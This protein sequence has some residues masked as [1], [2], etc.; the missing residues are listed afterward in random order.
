MEIQKIQTGSLDL[1]QGL[2]LTDL[3]L[4]IL[5]DIVSGKRVQSI[6]QELG[7]P[8][9][10]IITLLSK[11]KV[12]EFMQ[13]MIDARNLAIKMELPNLLTKIIQDKIDA[14]E[15]DGETLGSTSRKDIVDIIKVLSDTLK[16]TDTVQTK[17]EGDSF[18]N[19]YQKIN[20]IQGG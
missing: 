8:K 15:A 13:Q 9:A 6:S 1:P 14:A 17:E 18:T 3:E 10:S 7:V 4:M 20:V 2:H 16:T 11:E 5:K 19:I 12:K